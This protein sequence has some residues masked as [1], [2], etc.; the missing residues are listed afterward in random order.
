MGQ[1]DYHQ[2]WLIFPYDSA[3]LAIPLSPPPAKMQNR[4]EIP[5]PHTRC[6]QSIEEKP[7]KNTTKATQRCVGTCPMARSMSPCTGG[8]GAPSIFR[9]KNGRS[10]GK[11][12]PKRPAQNNATNITNQNGTPVS[13]TLPCAVVSFCAASVMASPEI[14]RCASVSEPWANK[15]IIEAPWGSEEAADSCWSVAGQLRA[16]R[17]NNRP[18]SPP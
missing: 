9:D 1:V 14:L 15:P 7:N 16:R 10:L 18:L 11:S 6:A 12:Q 3:L 4:M 17:L 2:L 13:L 5:G 8:R